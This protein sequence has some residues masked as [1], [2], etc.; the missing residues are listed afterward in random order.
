[1]FGDGITHGRPVSSQYISRRQPPSGTTSR[2][3][4]MPNA[5]LNS[6][7]SSPIVIPCR[8]GMGN[9]PTNDSNPGSSIGPSS[10]RPPIGFGRSQTNTVT[11]CLAAARRQFAI[12]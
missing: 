7:A 1:M 8:I 10:A 2:S 11:P 4:P 12:V 6:R 9:I 5:S 3:A